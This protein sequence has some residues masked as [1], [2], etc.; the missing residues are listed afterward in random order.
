MSS[1]ANAFDIKSAS[2][3]LLALILH[4]DNLEELTSALDARFGPAGDA[5][6]EAFM[7]DVEACPRQRKPN[8]AGCCPC[9][10][11]MAFA[12]WRCAIRIQPW[13]KWPAATAGLCARRCLP[14]PANLSA[15][16]KPSR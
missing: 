1:A 15:K 2:L 10:A 13:L 7:L 16:A 9:S 11:A 14:A 8:M 12:L 4:T 5:P 3:D 6:A